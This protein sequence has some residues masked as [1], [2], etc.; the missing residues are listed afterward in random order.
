MLS[1]RL[2]YKSPFSALLKGW[3]GKQREVTCALDDP[4]LETDPFRAQYVRSIPEAQLY[5][6]VLLQ[7]YL[8]PADLLESLDDMSIR[9]DDV[10]IITYPKSG[11]ISS[12]TFHRA[13]VKI[14]KYF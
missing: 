12:Y 1:L 10:F 9:D 13:L 4:S 3:M 11:T 8:V 5:R 7:G 6:G 2:L 14:F